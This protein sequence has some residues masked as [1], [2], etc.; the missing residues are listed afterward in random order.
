MVSGGLQN[1]GNAEQ[2]RAAGL[3]GDA[4]KVAG[5]WADALEQAFGTSIARGAQL[6]AQQHAL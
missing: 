1:E 2:A 6:A 4:M 5:Q 3:L